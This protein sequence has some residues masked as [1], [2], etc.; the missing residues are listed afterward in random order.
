MEFRLL[1]ETHDPDE[2]RALSLEGKRWALTTPLD[3]HSDAA[4]VAAY[5]CISYVWGAARAPNPVH[6]SVQMSSHTLPALRTAMHS[7]GA[8]FWMDAFCVPLERPAKRAT[9]ESMGFI[10]NRAERVVVVLTKASME[11]FAQMAAWDMKGAAAPPR[12]P[13]D[14]LERDMWIRSVWTYQEVVNSRNLFFAGEDSDAAL[15][16]GNTFLSAFGY[17]LATYKKWN[18][19]AS[20][21]LRERYPYLDAFE[22]LIADW[23]ISKYGERSAYLVIASM[24]RRVWAEDAN[25]FYSMIGAITTQP[26]QRTSNPTTATLAD[27]FMIVCEAKGDYS[28]IFCANE[29][30]VRPGLTWR[31][32]P[33]ILLAVM[34]WHSFGEMQW[35]ERDNRGVLTLKAMLRLERSGNVG[36]EGKRIIGAFL[37]LEDGLPDASDDEIV[38]RLVVALGHMGFTGSSVPLMMSEGYFFPQWPIAENQDVAVWASSS[39]L[40]VMGAPSIA[41]VHDADEGKKSYIPGV[42]MGHVHTAAATE[43]VI[44]DSIVHQIRF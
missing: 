15:V 23:L 26:S 39:I 6:P 20:V 3:I 13:L 32:Q 5:T 44:E 42:F 40:W 34:P 43:L 4:P 14:V 11:A 33:E 8:A 17:Y 30:D 2:H 28:F 10:Y 25:Y 31:P 7:G 41:V 19:M 37:A 35:G 24:Q 9:L 1:T 36:K 12:E 22:D 21:A 38:G 16:D 27:A 18:N 29:R